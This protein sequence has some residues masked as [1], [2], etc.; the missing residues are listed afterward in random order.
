[1]LDHNKINQID[2]QKGDRYAKN[3]SFLVRT[4]SIIKNNTIKVYCGYIIK[5]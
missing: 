1:M 4:E 2:M 3:K 5:M